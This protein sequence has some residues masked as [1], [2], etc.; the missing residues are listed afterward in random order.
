M[1]KE[2]LLQR[3]VRYVPSKY[4]PKKRRRSKLPCK[5]K[6]VNA[7]VV[8]DNVTDYQ[9]YIQM[10]QESSYSYLKRFLKNERLVI[11]LYYKRGWG[12]RRIRRRTGL[13]ERF[14]RN[15]LKMVK[16]MD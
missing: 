5:Y 1:E 7:E 13:S 3:K 16:E 14:T 11:F 9:D 12:R 8:F 10:E 15:I 2:Y 4:I 6:Y